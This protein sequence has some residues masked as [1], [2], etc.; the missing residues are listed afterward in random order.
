MKIVT[1]SSLWQRLT[2]PSTEARDSPEGVRRDCKSQNSQGQG[3]ETMIYKPGLLSFC[4]T[5]AHGCT[6]TRTHAP[7]TAYPLPSVPYRHHHPLTTWWEIV[8]IPLPFTLPLANRVF[9]LRHVHCPSLCAG[10]LGTGWSGE[11]T[12][13]IWWPSGLRS[14]DQLEPTEKSIWAS[15]TQGLRFAERQ[16]VSLLTTAHLLLSW[17]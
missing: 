17:K 9:N 4:R 13:H 16:S 14:K 1:N 2:L 6:C 11:R 5:H 10:W 7:Q 8:L 12:S 3:H 15:V